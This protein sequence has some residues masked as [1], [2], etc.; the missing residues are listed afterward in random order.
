M[1][2]TYDNMD[3]VR[4]S[5]L[6]EI[7]KSPMHYQYAITHPRPETAALAFGSAAHKYILETDDF[8]NEYVLAPECDRRTKEGKALWNQFQAELA[9]TGKASLSISDY[10]TIE[11][12]NEAV[13]RNPTAAALLKTGRHEVPIQWVDTKTGELCKCRVDCLTEWCGEKYI[14]DYK[15]TTSCEEGHFER[16]CRTYGYKLQAAMYLEGIFNETFDTYKFAFVAQEKNPPY[17]V[18][19]YFCDQGFIDEGMDQFRELIGLYHECKQAGYWPG[20]A[21]KELL[22]NE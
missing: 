17:A 15:T 21:D 12:M 3:G 20:Y 19:V 6:W 16:S 13:L 5:A 4:R 1:F 8:L 7:R 10:T 2:D 14:V 9:S 18:R 22:G 11:E